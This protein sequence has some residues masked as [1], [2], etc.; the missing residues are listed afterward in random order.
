MKFE[1]ISKRQQAKPRPHYQQVELIP[2]D[3]DEFDDV[4]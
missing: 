3:A 1:K 4:F 2:I